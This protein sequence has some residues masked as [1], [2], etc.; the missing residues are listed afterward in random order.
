MGCDA[1]R[2]PRC[3]ELGNVL[4]FKAIGRVGPR[5]AALYLSLQPFFEA[6]FAVIVLSERL[7]FLQ[8]AGGLMVLARVILARARMSAAPPAE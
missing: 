2:G 5:C 8:L 3:S 1:V 4:W 7:T 6:I